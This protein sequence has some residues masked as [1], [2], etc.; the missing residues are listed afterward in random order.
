MVPAALIPGIPRPDTRNPFAGK[1]LAVT[2]ALLLR[3]TEPQSIADL[4]TRAEVSRPLASKVVRELRRLELVAGEVRQGKQGE[5]WPTPA[6][7]EETASHWPAPSATVVGGQA[8][9]ESLPTGGGPTI[10]RLLS[11][12]W[13]APPR[14]YVR[15]LD[16]ARRVLA[17]S[18]GH[19][20]G[21]GTGDWEIAVVDFPFGPGEVPP[22]VAA[23]ELGATPRGREMLGRHGS[24]L[25]AGWR[26]HG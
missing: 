7:L 14:V 17:E 3:P 26:S 18:G 24:D 20:I 9:L 1:G 13:D 21:G 22:V 23:L 6:L 15:D 5:L 12:N 8:R 11:A 4:A 25:T 19:L 2:L 16:A 10:R